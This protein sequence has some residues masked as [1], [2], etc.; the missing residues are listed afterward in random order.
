MQRFRRLVSGT[1]SAGVDSFKIFGVI[2]S[3]PKDL[4]HLILPRKDSIYAGLIE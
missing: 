1:A 2:L 3:G 4:L